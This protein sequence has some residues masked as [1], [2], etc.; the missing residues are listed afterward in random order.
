M[1]VIITGTTGYVGEGVL[2][3]CLEHPEIEK[4][5]SV[6]RR[7]TN[8]EHP[9]LEE[10]VVDD[11]MNLQTG[12]ARLAGYDAVFFIAGITSVGTPEDVYLKISQTIPLHF[13]EILPDKEQMTY[14][15]LSG[16]GTNA[17]GKLAW[18]KIKGGTENALFAM[19]FKH[20]FGFRPSIMRPHPKQT[21]RKSFQI[22]S[23]ILYPIMWPFCQSNTMQEVANAMICCSK[24]GY[25]KKHISVRD[26]RKLSRKLK[27]QK[28]S[29]KHIEK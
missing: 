24:F 2:L 10:L 5:L 29:D 7:P 16:E 27:E 4:I 28:G 14:I 18:Q 26:I 21:T 6:S 15:Y 20:A 17:N 19:P 25:E 13:A 3:C 22:A 1:K 11:F 12:D 9:K 8:I 23:R